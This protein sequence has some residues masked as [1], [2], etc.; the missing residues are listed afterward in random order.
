[1]KEEKEIVFL[2][3]GRVCRDMEIFEGFLELC[4][5]LSVE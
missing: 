4:V 2:L 3:E 1:M 5:G